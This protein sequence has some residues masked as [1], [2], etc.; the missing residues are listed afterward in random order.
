MVSLKPAV[1]TAV[2]HRVVLHRVDFTRAAAELR[3]CKVTRGHVFRA[4]DTRMPACAATGAVV[5]T[6]IP[7]RPIGP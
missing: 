5:T 2:L 7:Y 1:L 3:R 4:A 6:K